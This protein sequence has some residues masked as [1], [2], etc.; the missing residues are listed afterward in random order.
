MPCVCAV[1]RKRRSLQIVASS[2]Q[3]CGEIA[4]VASDK[5]PKTSPHRTKLRSP[6]GCFALSLL[7]VHALALCGAA[8]SDLASADSR[9]AR[10]AFLVAAL[11]THA[12]A[13]DAHSPPTQIHIQPQA[14]KVRNS[15]AASAGGARPT[16][17]RPE[18]ELDTTAK[19]IIGSHVA[20]FVA[21][22]CA[23]VV[24]L[25]ALGC[26][27]AQSDVSSV[28]L[29]NLAAADFCYLMLLPLLIQTE[30]I[31]FWT[32]NSLLCKAY[33]T[34][35]C[36]TQFTSSVFVMLNGFDKYYLVCHPISAQR[37]RKLASARK[38]AA[39]VWLL[40]AAMMAPV[41]SVA[42][43]VRRPRRLFVCTNSDF[44]RFN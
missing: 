3:T 17:K 32:H 14:V 15:T 30:L 31:G 8:P 24:V 5:P 21:G 4:S 13:G 20:S 19:L 42:Q 26:L 35:S 22:V 39:C 28:L 33:M 27:Q 11:G 38:L 6:L 25:L 29:L 34:V 10:P 7:M 41:V 43:L 23:N 40:G 9:S 37:N 1:Q 44:F 36:V 16:R 12:E 2:Q 18:R